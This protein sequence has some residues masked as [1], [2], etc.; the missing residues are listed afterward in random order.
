MDSAKTDLLDSNQ[1][2]YNYWKIKQLKTDRTPC[3][4]QI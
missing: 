1:S 4:E 3:A 2:S